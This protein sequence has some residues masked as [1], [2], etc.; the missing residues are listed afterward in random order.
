MAGTVVLIDDDEHTR[1]RL[2]NALER[3][4]IRVVEHEPCRRGLAALPDALPDVYVMD[5]VMPE[6]DGFEFLREIRSEQPHI[7]VL[8]YS[9]ADR[10][11]IQFAE[12]LGASVAIDVTMPDQMEGLV[13]AVRRMVA[14]HGIARSPVSSG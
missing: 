12:K 13:E 3:E 9:Q 11:Y 14:K 1:R 7:P 10:H 4:S 6:K 2:R 8:A 5:I